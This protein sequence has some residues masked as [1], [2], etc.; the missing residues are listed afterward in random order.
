MSLFFATGYSQGEIDYQDKIFFRNERTYGLNLNSNGFGVNFRYAKRIDGFS[1]TLYEGEFNYLKHPK[2]IKGSIPNTNRSIIFGKLNSAY[3]LKFGIGYQK[4]MFPKKD[5]G[6]ISIR[7]FANFGPSAAFLKPLYYEYLDKNRQSTFFDKF[8]NQ[9]HGSIIGR[10]TFNMGFNEL[11]VKPGAYAKF[12][13]TFEYSK[14]DEIFHALELG[15][16]IDAYLLP[17]KIMD[18]P[19]EKI[20]FLL[21]DDQF[22]ITLFIGYRFGKVIERQFTPRK[23]RLD[24]LITE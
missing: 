10:G 8:Q 23:N 4:E 11:S 12:G 6:G 15:I 7:Y 20:L 21:P 19:R 24:K 22:F 2:E 16:G 18:A 13:F 9:N 14:V 3:S 1:K 17:L 5:F